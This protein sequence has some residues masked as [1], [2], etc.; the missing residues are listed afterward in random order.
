MCLEQPEPLAAARS[1]VGS[2][3]LGHALSP[4]LTSAG[5]AREEDDDHAEEEADERSQQRPDRD[6]ESRMAARIIFVD[7]VMQDAKQAEINRQ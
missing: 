7:V 5:A 4:L 6:A 1:T 3:L 2:L